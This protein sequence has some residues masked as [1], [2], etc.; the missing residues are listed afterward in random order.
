[1]LPPA[2]LVLPTGQQFPKREMARKSLAVLAWP[3]KTTKVAKFLK[4]ID[5]YIAAVNL[6]FTV[7][8]A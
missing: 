3:L 5:E 6:A 8:T 4:E 2:Q 7:E 1:M